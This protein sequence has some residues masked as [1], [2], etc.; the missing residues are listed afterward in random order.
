VKN[1]SEGQKAMEEI[2]NGFK[3]LLL[4]ERQILNVSQEADDEGTSALM[5]DYIREQEKTVWMFSSYL[6]KR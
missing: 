1:I 2:L 4:K 3:A 5:S 6:G